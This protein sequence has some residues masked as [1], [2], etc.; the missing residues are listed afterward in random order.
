QVYIFSIEQSPW[1]AKDGMTVTLFM[2]EWQPQ[3]KR[4]TQKTNPVAAPLSGGSGIPEGR[5]LTA[6]SKRG[7]PTP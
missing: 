7:V 1:T 3:E 2:R 6:P 4:K 5:D